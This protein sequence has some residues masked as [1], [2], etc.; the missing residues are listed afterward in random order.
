MWGHD[1]QDFPETGINENCKQMLNMEGFPADLVSWLIEG[2]R[3][4]LNKV[5]SKTMTD[6]S[7]ESLA[8]RLIND[9]ERIKEHIKEWRENV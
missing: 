2:L 6:K 8:N 3:I 5:P 1:G 7:L 9:G 4:E